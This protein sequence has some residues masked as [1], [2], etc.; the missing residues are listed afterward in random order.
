MKPLKI[1]E[2]CGT[3]FQAERATKR[4]HTDECRL[5]AWKQAHPRSFKPI[6]RRCVECGELFTPTTPGAAFCKDLCRARRWEKDHPRTGADAAPAS[7][8]A[9]KISSPPT[10]SKFRAEQALQGIRTL[11]TGYHN[12]QR[13]SQPGQGAAG[14]LPA[15]SISSSG[16]MPEAPS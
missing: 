2:Y 12:P 5:A 10:A 3:P 9:E 16:N 1:C 6:Q 8:P 7:G 13:S 15:G 11:R 14:I 4:F